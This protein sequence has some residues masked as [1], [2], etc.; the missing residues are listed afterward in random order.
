MMQIYIVRMDHP[1]G[2]GWNIFVREHVI[3]LKGLIEQGKLLASGPLKNTPLRA[4]FL[5]FRA[6]TRDEVQSM[7]SA[8]PFAREGLIA[9]LEIHEWDPLFGQL[10]RYSSHNTVSELQDLIG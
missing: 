10:D 9:K 4:G 1:D 8:D 2:T 7:I 5:I 6:E 3:Y